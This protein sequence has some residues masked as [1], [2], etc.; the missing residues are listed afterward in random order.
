ML[1]DEAA[2]VRAVASG[3]PAERPLS[4]QFRDRFDRAREVLVLDGRVHELVVDP[5]PAVRGDLVPRRGDPLHEGRITLGHPAENEKGGLDAGLVEDLQQ[6][7]G[8]PLHPALDR[9]PARTR[10]DPVE[11]ADVE[12]ILHVDGHRVQHAAHR[13]P[14]RISTVFT[15]FA[16]MKRSNASVRFLM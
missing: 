15:V 11:R 14:L 7:V 6:A 1:D 4:R 3:V 8:V 5:A 9:R 12:V 10:H 2:R 13:P 16:R